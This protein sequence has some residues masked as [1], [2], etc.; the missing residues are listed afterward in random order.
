[1][2]DHHW[3]TQAI[4]RPPRGPYEVTVRLGPDSEPAVLK[5]SPILEDGSPMP[6]RFYLVHPT[7]V[8][9]VSS[10]ESA[11]AVRAADVEVDP[12]A[13]SAT[14]DAYA[15]ER[16]AALPADYDGPRPYGGVGGTRR[17]VKCLHA[18]VANWM[19]G[20]D[21]PVGVWTVARLEADA[22]QFLEANGYPL[23]DEV[24]FPDRDPDESRIT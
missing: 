19:V 2:D 14:H 11:G 22:R 9:A 6:T 18:H 20:R 23:P 17:G 3:L 15:A 1:M 12:V 21:D 10:L 5:T 24:R 4:G 7:L 13:L 16:D 8:A